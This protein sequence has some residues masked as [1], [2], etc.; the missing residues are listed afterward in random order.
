[1]VTDEQLAALAAAGDETAAETLVDRYRAFLF[2]AT[3]RFFDHSSGVDDLLQEARIGLFKAWRDFNPDAGVTFASF[4]RMCIDRQLI[5][6]IKTARR[7]KHQS[8]TES[9]RVVE[10]D[11][12]DLV[13]AVSMLEDPRADT[14]QLIS[15]RADFAAIARVITQELTKRERGVLELWLAGATYLEIATELGFHFNPHPVSE[16]G[17]RSKTV[18]NALQRARRKL[19]AVIEVDASPLGAVA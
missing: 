10:N 6:A 2:W 18:D 12:G 5:T 8:L 16:H 14:V 4:A 15:D 3:Q 17:V 11:D 7:I 13:E 9:M 19:A 1:M